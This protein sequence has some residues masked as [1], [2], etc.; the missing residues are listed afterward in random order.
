MSTTAEQIQHIYIGLL[1]RAADKAGLT[2]WADEIDAGI[3]TLDQVRANFVEQQPE[4]AAGLGSMTRAQAV[5]ELY[6]RMFERAPEPAG[7]AYWT[8]GDGSSVTIDRLASTFVE[9]ALGDDITALRNKTEAAQFYTTESGSN[10]TSLSALNAI[11]SVDANAASVAASKAAT[12]AIFSSNDP[13]VLTTGNDLLIGTTSNDTFTATQDTYTASDV[14]ADSTLTDNDRL[15]ITATDD[16]SLTPAVVGIENINFNLN[17]FTTSGDNANRFDVATSGIASGIIRL[18]V[19]QVGSSINDALVS[20]VIDGVT[21]ATSNDFSTL[22]VRTN[23]TNDSY[24]VTAQ[25]TDFKLDEGGA[26]GKDVT[27]T[28]AGKVTIGTTAYTSTGTLTVTAADDITIANADTAKSLTATSNGGRVVVTSADAATAVTL[29]ATEDADIISAATILT[30]TISA[31]GTNNDA[32]ARDSSIVSETLSTANLSGNGAGVEYLVS[33]ATS[34]STINVTGNQHVEIVTSGAMIEGL[35][36]SNKLTINDQSTADITLTISGDA[37]DMD[38]L[39]A[40]VDII[41]LETS[42]SAKTLTVLPDS[43]VRIA[44][45]Q[46]TGSTVASAAVTATINKL[47]LQIN[48]N[49][50]GVSDITL[51]GTV[52]S[53]Y[54]T[55]NLALSDN[56]VTAT[57]LD[58]G[59]A[60]LNLSGGAKATFVGSTTATAINGAGMSASLSVELD[61]NVLKATGGLAADTFNISDNGNYVIDGGAS[62]DKILF[63]EDADT[64]A[65]TLTLSDIEVFE[66]AG[67]AKIDASTVSVKSY[68]M[69]GTSNDVSEITVVADVAVIDLSSLTIDSTELSMAV[70]ASELGATSAI[71]ITGSKGADSVIGSATNINTLD[72]GDGADTL[73]SASNL[74]DVI[75]LGDSSATTTDTVTDAGD[76]D[77]SISQGEGL[78]DIRAGEGN[79]LI[80]LEET[81]SATDIVRFSAEDENGN[82]T[83]THFETASD[84]LD[85]SAIVSSAINV[86]NAGS[87]TGGTAIADENLYIINNSSIALTSGGAETI[88]DYYDLADIAAY[89]NEGFNDAADVSAGATSMFALNTGTATHLFSYVANAAATDTAI[90][91]DELSIIG[92]ITETN[93]ND[94]AASDFIISA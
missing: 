67:A 60:T 17:A 50:A 21:I 11:N 75:K 90:T 40:D 29:K 52:F 57:S 55:I 32:T 47:N 76:G 65:D 7:F 42:N 23:T 93:R 62:D 44:A 24:K 89:L 4:Y 33:E 26:A 91:G 64:T 18:D 86:A 51:D 12:S 10:Y 56:L 48:D 5:T 6:S 8:T 16:I 59:S 14:I 71:N 35:N 45:S 41:S 73:V 9:A 72:L 43:T 20:G 82:D 2:Y 37:G 61:G 80:F 70:D 22:D 49:T 79:D 25:A 3:I 53:N 78:S 85:I 28:G 87:V 63:A 46:E 1:G 27:V 94:L 34:L 13:V 88:A 69:T 68:N 84:K 77:D 36:D 15:I 58:A 83:I 74:K 39:T 19:T 30:A 66:F 81:V 92:V 38:L 31:A 54:K